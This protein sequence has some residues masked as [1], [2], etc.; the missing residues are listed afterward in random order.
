MATTFYAKGA[1]AAAVATKLKRLLPNLDVDF[2]VIADEV[3]EAVQFEAVATI[4]QRED[5]LQQTMVSLLDYYRSAMDGLNGR[6]TQLEAD[7][8]A[9]SLRLA[10]RIGFAD[11]ET[12]GI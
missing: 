9:L 11:S 2:A 1:V 7:R 12:A 10:E 6:I 5:A 4:A 3:V 8:T